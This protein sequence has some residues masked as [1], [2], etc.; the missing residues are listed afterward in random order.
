M[1]GIL[2]WEMFFDVFNLFFKVYFRVSILV[3]F[4]SIYYLLRK[5]INLGKNKFIGENNEIFE[6]YSYNKRSNKWNKLY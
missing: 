1:F 3:F 2:L 6:K 4:F 5:L